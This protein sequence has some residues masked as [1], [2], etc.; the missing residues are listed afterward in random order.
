MQDDSSHLY[1]APAGLP[2]EASHLRRLAVLQGVPED[3]IITEE[4]ATNTLEN[5][6]RTLPILQALSIRAVTVVTSDYHLPRARLFFEAVFCGSNISLGFAEV[7]WYHQ[8]A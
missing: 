2:T 3:A 1:I 7:R 6:L 5:A 4:C 8:E